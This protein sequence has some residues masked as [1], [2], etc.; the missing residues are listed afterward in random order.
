[1]IIGIVGI[2]LG[3]ALL[4]LFLLIRIRRMG[5]RS[6]RELEKLAF[7]DSLTGYRNEQKFMID[8]EEAIRKNSE[9]NYAILYADIKN[10]KYVNEIFGYDVG[11]KLLKYWADGI[12]KTIRDGEVFARFNV[13]DTNEDME[14]L[15][16]PYETSNYPQKNNREIFPNPIDKRCFL[17]YDIP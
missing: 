4:F 3:S 5:E 11:D 15:F 7:V 8:A 14:P 16:N 9:E 13:E 10:F 17:C 2:I 1:M 12:N 6:R